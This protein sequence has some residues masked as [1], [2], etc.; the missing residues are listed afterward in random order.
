[1]LE[2][3]DDVGSARAALESAAA[4][5]GSLIMIEGPAGIGKS[6]LLGEICEQAGQAGFRVVKASGD[7]LET[8]YPS[9]VA[10]R[11]FAPLLREGEVDAFSGPARA[12]HAMLEGKPRQQSAPGLLHSLF[13]LVQDLAEERPLLLVV[14]DLHWA[15]AQSLRVIAHLA[16]RVT[17]MPVLLLCGTRPLGEQPEPVREMIRAIGSVPGAATRR[18]AP[19]SPA[20]VDEI[21]RES[22]PAP[23]PDMS[24]TCAAITRGNPFLLHELLAGLAGGP[25]PDLAKR[26]GE[27]APETVRRST[28]GRLAALG[29]AALPLA[30]AAAVLGEDAKLRRAAEIADLD[31]D[32]AGELADA[33]VAA[34]IAESTDPLLFS[35][36][37][38]RTATL[39]E[40]GKA[41]SAAMA[42]RAAEILGREGEDSQRVA[43]YLLNARRGG[44]GW[45]VDVLLEAGLSSLAAGA[46]ES[47]V[48]MLG[49][50]LDEPPSA[51]RRGEVLLALGRAEAIAGIDGADRH[52]SEA[53]ALTDDPRRAAEAYLL[54]GRSLFS[55]GRMAEA[56][57]A[58]E[59]GA[60][61]LEGGVDEELATVLRASWI[62]AAIWDSARSAEANTAAERIV[63]AN[64]P[65]R[66]Q[67]ERMMLS[68]LA[69]A[70][71]F[72]G[73]D[74]ERAVDLARRSWAA[75]ALLAEGSADDPTIYAVSGVLSLAGFR[76]EAVAVL[77]EALA[78]AR[79]RGAELAHATAVY[80]RGGILFFAGE[81]REAIA[82]LEL[83]DRR[84][85]Q[86]LERL[87]SCGLRDPPAGACRRRA[88]RRARSAHLRSELAGRELGCQQHPPVVPARRGRDT[89]PCRRAR[90][91][92]G[93]ADPGRRAVRDRRAAE[94]GHRS[95]AGDARGGAEQARRS[96]TGERAGS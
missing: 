84:A 25:E 42:L 50:A 31:L 46:P 41:S 45:V 2:R 43:I 54:A 66:S 44:E 92:P 69:S 95:L 22:I 79:S 57:T 75:G 5:Y 81:L 13:W 1:M 6:R 72:A 88:R 4:G 83:A 80:C 59:R 3:E 26:I 21:V 28:I 96:R 49:R 37:L 7:Q 65:G 9:G 39:D 8:E 33:M 53:A 90:G 18:L 93:A 15:D 32:S 61:P 16:R 36:P 48:A 91:R 24:V 55:E 71:V 10:R 94:P 14:D 87:P 58:F 19:L 35:H 62:T 40:A 89:R 56:A 23:D 68:T 86:R 76:E 34:E 51:E 64:L 73:L 27:S 20:A 12:A 78:D 82:D 47:A 67:A 70:K 60:E 85:P 77:D 38:V 52:L 30:A 11:L 29:P 74:R 17:E 63:A